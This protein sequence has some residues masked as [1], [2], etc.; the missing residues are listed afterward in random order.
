MPLPGRQGAGPA[1]PTEVPGSARPCPRGL[2]GHR[3]DEDCGGRGPR[4]QA[5]WGP[6][7]EGQSSGSLYLAPFSVTTNEKLA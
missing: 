6:E 5:K 7:G 4:G 2:P 3:L 1:G